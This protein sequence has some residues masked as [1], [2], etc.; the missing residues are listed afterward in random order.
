M[1]SA[2]RHSELTNAF[3]AVCDKADW[4]RPIKAT[5]AA[6]A[7]TL[8]VEAIMFFTATEATVTPTADAQFVIVET[9][10]YRAGPAG[11]H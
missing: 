4:K 5:I 7:A 8:T 6:E 9:I 10:G 11:D 3:N 2:E 1:I